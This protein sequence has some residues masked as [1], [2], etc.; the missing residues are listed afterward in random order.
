MRK[1]LGFFPLLLIVAI[2][3]CALFFFVFRV[4]L[5]DL[6]VVVAVPFVWVFV[7]SRLIMGVL[8]QPSNA[9]PHKTPVP[10]QPPTI[11]IRLLVVLFVICFLGAYGAISLL[12]SAATFSHLALPVIASETLR[13][14][15]F[16]GIAA[17]AAL[18]IIIFLIAGKI[19]S[20]H[21]DRFITGVWYILQFPRRLLDSL[22]LPPHHLR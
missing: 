2:V 17:L 18:L 20:Q 19:A 3:G 14:A 15:S 6:G 1:M 22:S 13:L 4:A 16:F 11:V 10:T 7:I 12:L 8:P 5:D 9:E 21:S